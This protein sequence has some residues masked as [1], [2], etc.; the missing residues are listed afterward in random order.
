MEFEYCLYV[1]KSHFLDLS[2]YTL[3]LSLYQAQSALGS[4]SQSICMHTDK[5]WSEKQV[6]VNQLTNIW[7]LMNIQQMTNMH[8]LKSIQWHNALSASITGFSRIYHW[9]FW[10]FSFDFA[11]SNFHFAKP[12]ICVHSKSA[13]YV[14]WLLINWAWG[15]MDVW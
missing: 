13:K 15:K 10:G 9:I 8:Q 12:N 7:Q 6:L 14:T 2:L 5:Y 3:L 4:S 1:C 11:L